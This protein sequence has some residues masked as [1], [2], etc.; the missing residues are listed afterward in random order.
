MSEDLDFTLLPQ[1]LQPL[2]ELIARFGESDDVGRTI[3]LT[4]ASDEDLRDLVESARPRW[5]AINRYLDENM[6]PPGPRQD[7]AL[8]L[9]G[10]A[11]AAMEARG[12]QLRRESGEE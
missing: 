4:N 9:D 7:V 5:D 8:A 12:E 6:S 3:L 2:A 10:F 11:Q 1:E